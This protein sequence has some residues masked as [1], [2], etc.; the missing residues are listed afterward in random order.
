[1]KKTVLL[2]LA[3][4]HFREVGISQTGR[5]DPSF[6]SK[7]IVKTDVGAKYNYETI[8]KQTLLQTDGS[9]YVIVRTGGQTFIKKKR[10]NGSVDSSYGENGSSVLVALTPVCAAFQP[11]GKIVVA[12]TKWNGNV[13]ESNLVRYNTNGSADKT[14]NGYG[15]KKASFPVTSMAIQRDGKIVIGGSVYDNDVSYFAL[16]RYTANGSTDTSF[17]NDGQ[18]ITDFKFSAATGNREEF[19]ENDL[20]NFVSIQSDGKIFLAGSIFNYSTASTEFAIA[21]YNADGSPD[22]TFSSDG[23]QTTNF[24]SYENYSYSLGFQADGKIIAAGYTGNNGSYDFAVARYNKNGSL[25]KTFSGDGKQTQSIG[26]SDHYPTTIAVQQDGKIVVEGAAFNGSN[27]DFVVTRCNSD[28]SA[29]KTFDNDGK[30]ITDFG[31]GD[32]FANSIAIQNDGKVLVGGYSYLNTNTGIN[33]HFDIA[34]YNTNGSLDNSFDNDGKLSE[35]L[36]QGYT[37][38]S[39]AVV[40]K[41]GKIVVGGYSWNGKNNDFTVIRYNTNGSL[42][43]SFSSDGKQMTDFGG[44]DYANSIAIQGDGKI[45]VGGYSINGNAHFAV[46]RYNTNGTL[47]NTFSSDGKEIATFGTDDFA[48]SVAVSSDGKIMVAGY[49]NTATSSLTDFAICRYNADGS[50]DNTFSADGKQLTDINL[51]DDYGYS[52]ALQADGKIVVAGNSWNGNDNDF[53]VVRYNNDGTL[54][55]TFSS[56]GRLITDFSFSDD[57]ATSVAI[58]SNGKIVAG[59]RTGNYGSYK[60]ALA[61]YNTD[62]TFDPTFSSDGKQTANFGLSDLSA[63]SVAVLESGKIIAAGSSNNHFAL[64]RF[65]TDGSTDNNFSNKGI[66]I[67]EVSAA[68]DKIQGIAVSRD[69]LYAAGYAQLPGTLGAVAR[70]IL[71]ENKA[72]VVSI[73]SPAAE[74]TYTSPATITINATATDA[75]GTIASVKFYNGSTYL[76]TIFSKPYTYVLSNLPAGTYSLT[77]K[78]TD[79]L[80]AQ[81][82]S[83]PVSVIVKSSNKAPVVSLT[84]PLNNAAYIAPATITITANALDSDGTVTNVKFYKGSTCLT[85]TYVSPFT[86]S[87]PNLPVGTY[88]FSAKATDNLGAVTS[89]S[90]VTVSVVKALAQPITIGPVKIN[91]K[92]G[93]DDLVGLK[94]SPNPANNIL[95]I[96]TTR[97]LPNKQLIVVITS[98]S[99]IIMLNSTIQNSKGLS[100]LDISS[101]V[102]GVYT[103]EVMCE[104]RVASKQFIKM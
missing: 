10:S 15:T 2:L 91:N 78:A 19:P 75:D 45:V 23:M 53:A 34:R 47:D 57:Y 51:S 41:D 72:P 92:P 35:G 37:I 38:Y 40:Q 99:G 25:D 4:S 76:K 13:D 84:S 22:N 85:T 42:D 12:G 32:D 93:L 74:T 16:A 59:G 98:T 87:L 50:L 43:K 6:G 29:D 1:M 103:V 20:G 61:R 86:Y 100:Q 30:L 90:T 66:Q 48:N 96:N 69:K 27:N 82:I 11:D 68:E 101:L 44:D 31:S 17:S 3:I 8:G 9:I 7:G 89:S 24:G 95:Q 58:Q 65:N 88:S 94:I 77:A 33:S 104:G 79:N 54:D 80:G 56:D 73:S 64:T 14:F 26:S 83:A 97:L 39:S 52:M 102:S 18:Q 63:N 21:K 71:D 28:G 70:Y 67:T 81:T 36:Q 49:S 60:I 46:A 5:L 55:N 62:G